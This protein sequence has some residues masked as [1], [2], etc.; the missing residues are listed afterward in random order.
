MKERRQL[1]LLSKHASYSMCASLCG[2]S[3]G[4]VCLP[5]RSMLRGRQDSGKEH[6]AMDTYR[7]ALDLLVSNRHF[8]QARE[9]LPILQRAYTKLN[10]EQ[11]S[12]QLPTCMVVMYATG[13]AVCWSLRIHHSPNR[14]RCSAGSWRTMTSWL[15]TAALKRTCRH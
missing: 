7:G 2:T 12:F 10:Q 11:K 1:L 15:L 9:L 4:G 3:G 6:W 5:H 13:A 8:T 14:H